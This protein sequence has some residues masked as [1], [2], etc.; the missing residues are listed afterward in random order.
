M[1]IVRR[2]GCTVAPVW[3]SCLLGLGGCALS[4]VAVDRVLAPDEVD[5]TAAVAAFRAAPTDAARAVEAARV[6]FA[7]A[8]RT[9]Q[10][11]LVS[12]GE[13]LLRHDADVAAVLANEAGLPATIRERVLSLASVG[14]E[15]AQAAVDVL[16]ERAAPAAEQAEANVL[17]ALHLSFVAWA[18]GPMRSLFAGYGGRITAAMERALEL[19]RH[20]D[21]GAPLRLDGRFRAQAPWP[22]RDLDRAQ[23]LLQ[24]A[25]AT[26]PLPL[27]HLF[28]GDLLF[29]RGDVEG[30]VQQWQLAIAAEPDES[31]RDVAEFHRELAR[32]RLRAAGRRP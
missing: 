19:D 21:H 4:P 9:V 12:S 6:L 30:A 10:Q 22:L 17:L 1:R 24:E 2:R 16:Q 7:A 29:V 31:T 27:H 11:E 15:A 25:V 8:D 20:W 14:A 18:N 5:T 23:R 3:L 13:E 26:A 28:Y 32:L